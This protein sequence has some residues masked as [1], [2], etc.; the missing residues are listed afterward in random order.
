MKGPPKQVLK[1]ISGSMPRPGKSLAA[2]A[3]RKKA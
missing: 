3:S 2:I 1:V